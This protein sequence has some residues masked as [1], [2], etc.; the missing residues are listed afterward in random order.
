M[1]PVRRALGVAALA[2]VAAAA[3]GA[4]APDRVRTIPAG[5]DLQQALDDAPRGSILRLEEGV[6]RG[7]IVIDRSVTLTGSKGS[8]VA[9]PPTEDAVVTVT[10]DGVVVRDLQVVGG[11]TG[12]A[13]REARDVR[14][15]SLSI[16]RSLMEG[17]DVAG[18]GARIHDV[19]VRSLRSPLAQGIE[20]RNSEHQGR[21]VVEGSS[22]SGGQEG[23]VAHVSRVRFDDNVVGGTTKHAISITEMSKGIAIGNHVKTVA[24]AGLYCGDMSLCAFEDNHVT[25]VRAADETRSGGGWALLVHYH[26][27]ASSSGDR[28]EAAAG[29]IGI[30]GDSHL[31]ERSPLRL[32]AGWRGIAPLV[33]VVPLSLA[34]VA[35]AGWAGHGFA[36]R[37]RRVA[38][39]WVTPL[40]VAGLAVQSFHMLEHW[41]QLYRVRFDGVPGRGGLVG[42][43][44]EAEWIHLAYNAAVLLA[45]L[46]VVAGRR[47]GW[48]R[49]SGVADAALAGACVVQGYHLVEHVAKVVQHV[50]TGAKVN[51]GFAGHV[52][53]LV[54]FHFAIN[55]AVYAGFVV[56]ALIAL[57]PRASTRP[58]RSRRAA[59][60]AE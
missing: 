16:A 37:Q 46:F 28:L 31:R 41:L 34:L 53:D 13:V 36:R 51:P 38:A 11:E 30:F 49:P 19:H 52:F 14:L 59:I 43:A 50:T 24:G 12:V 5:A 60:A 1:T 15:E 42:P 48:G 56:A 32:G 22:V 20:I 9:A 4:L 44:V 6:H 58:T 27:S 3:A 17:I 45:L 7:P 29:P 18:A 21:V 35:L 54:W 8:V 26:S 40:V 33:W 57:P 47:N 55:L 39:R 23:I 2:L 10:A 25:D